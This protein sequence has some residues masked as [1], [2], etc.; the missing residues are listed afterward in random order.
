MADGQGI[1]NEQMGARGGDEELLALAQWHLDEQTG[2]ID[3]LDRKLAATFTLSGALIAVLGAAFTLRTDEITQALWWVILAIVAVFIANAVCAF[4][5]FRLRSWE[6]RPDVDA[7]DRIAE[8][9]NLVVARTWAAQEMWASFNEN[10]AALAE[11]AAWLRRAVTLTTANLI[12][13]GIA[14]IVATWPWC[15]CP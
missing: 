4:F 9:N 14:A 5:A 2:R 13:A 3:A 8:E 11:K 12:L 7:F 10:E 1:E 15:F 6:M